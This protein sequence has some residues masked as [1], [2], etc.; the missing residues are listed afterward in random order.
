M[1]E[2]VS[3]TMLCMS[4]SSYFYIVLTVFCTYYFR[5]IVF[6]EEGNLLEEKPVDVNEVERRR[7]IA[8]VRSKVEDLIQRAKSSNEGMDFLV[9]SVMNIEASFGQIV[10]TIVQTTQEEYENFIGCRIP[11][12][13]EIHPPTDVCSKG[14]SKRIKKAKEL[15]K[16]RKRKNDN[17]VKNSV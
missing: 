4:F 17:N 5:E 13:V 12:Q 1:Q 6:D 7:K 11:E 15:P 8:A 14:R 16:S 10:P 3:A 2:V 9:T